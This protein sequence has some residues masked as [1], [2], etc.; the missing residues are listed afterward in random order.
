ML[1]KRLKLTDAAQLME[2]W[3]TEPEKYLESKLDNDY[4]ELRKQLLSEYQE[5]DNGK[6]YW[7]DYQFGLRLNR[8]LSKFG[9]TSR[10][11]S[12]DGIWRFLSLCVVPDLVGRRWGRGAEQ[13]F[14]SRA[15]RIWLKTIWW[16]IHLSWQGSRP[17]TLKVLARNTTDQIL[18]LVDRSGAKG[19][20]VET[21]RKIMYYYW[22]AR[23]INTSIGEKE[24]RQIMLLHTALCQSIEPGLY[25]GGEDGYVKMLFSRIGITV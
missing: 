5:V 10:D 12:D 19:Y 11:A 24:F 22:A 1:F 21:Y 25:D 20:Y 18:Q 8:T 14:Y 4:A 2:A 15:G 7:L 9:F 23:E 17:E 6:K 16:Y 13:R 3:K